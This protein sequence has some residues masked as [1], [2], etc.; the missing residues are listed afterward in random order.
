MEKKKN[1][2]HSINIDFNCPKEWLKMDKNGQNRHCQSCNQTV[3]DF[4]KLSDDEILD[5]FKNRT[6]KKICGRFEKP[7]LAQLNHKLNYNSNPLKSFR[8]VIKPLIVAAAI[9]SVTACSPT[10]HIADNTHE[11]PSS[12]IEIVKEVIN[13]DSLNT[14]LIQ[15]KIIA[16]DKEPLIGA[17]LRFDET[18]RGTITDVNGN[19]KIKLPKEAIKSETVTIS[20]VGFGSFQLQLID[21]QNKEINV[22]LAEPNYLIGDVI[23]IKQPLHKRIFNKNR[24]G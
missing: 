6:S 21:I 9:T 2:I 12:K 11:T 3:F 24:K 22:V 5:F 8:S 16:T 4:S 10:N 20:S 18:E 7:Q 23:I 13:S 17:V 19:F 1:D 14:I 15:G